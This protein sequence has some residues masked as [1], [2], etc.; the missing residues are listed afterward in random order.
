MFKGINNP[1]TTKARVLLFYSTPSL[2]WGKKY[3]EKSPGF[4]VSNFLVEKNPTYIEV[5]GKKN[6]KFKKY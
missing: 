2:I 3:E 1:T 6:I 5:K 4:I